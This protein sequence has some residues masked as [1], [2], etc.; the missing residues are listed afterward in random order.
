MH[1]GAHLPLIDFDGS[2]YSPGLLASFTDAAREAG[3]AALS[4]N[5]HFVF[6]RPWLDGIVAL[7]S[8][9][10]RSGSMTLATTVSLP[11]VRGP[12]ALAKAAAALDILSDGRMVL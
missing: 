11:V 8:V 6:Q 9:V 7:S 4:A 10:E 12:V 3:F 5:D 1:L 2:G